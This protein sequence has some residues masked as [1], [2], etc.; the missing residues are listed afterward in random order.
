[1]EHGVIVTLLQGTRAHLSQIRHTPVYRPSSNAL[2]LTYADRDVRTQLPV[3]EKITLRIRNSTRNTPVTFYWRTGN[4]TYEPTL[5][6]SGS[7]LTLCFSK[8]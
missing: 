2:Q 7:G 5:A 8:R 4:V 6:D 3:P 1:M